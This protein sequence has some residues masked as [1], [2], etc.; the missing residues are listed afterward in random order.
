MK[1]SVD[2]DVEKILEKRSGGTESA[3]MVLATSFERVMQPYVPKSDGANVHLI[4]Q[5]Q[6][7][8]KGKEKA[9]IVY[10]GP[11]AHYVYVGEVYGP[12]FEVEPGV[13][14]SHKGKKKTKTDRKI[15][16]TGA[17]MRGAEWDKRAWQA[18]SK[19]VLEALAKRMG[20]EAK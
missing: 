7:I 15:N 13:W 20:G 4:Q 5:V 6:I 11:Y 3:A 19:E 8:P 10:P 17:P 2:I 16:Y 14:R 9:E 18:R 1:I 12:N